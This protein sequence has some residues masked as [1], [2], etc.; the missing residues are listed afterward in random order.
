LTRH[1]KA[2]AGLEGA[3]RTLNERVPLRKLGEIGENLP[4]P[5]S[6]CANFNFVV[7]R[8]MISLPL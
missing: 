5:F 8:F 3:A 2:F 6:R 7:Q 1:F 4:D